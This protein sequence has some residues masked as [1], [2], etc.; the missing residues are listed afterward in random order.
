MTEK[1]RICVRTDP[2]NDEKM[3]DYCLESTADVNIYTTSTLQNV[4]IMKRDKVDGKILVQ[5]MDM[6]QVRM[7]YVN[8]CIP[9]SLFNGSTNIKCYNESCSYDTSL[10]TAFTEIVPPQDRWPVL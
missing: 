6:P 3:R 4:R 10:I 1:Q 2:L 7:A 5:Y 8:N 9:A